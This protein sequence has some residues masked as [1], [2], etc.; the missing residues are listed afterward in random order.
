MI[1]EWTIKKERGNWRPLLE[2]KMKKEAWEKALRVA[3]VETRTPFPNSYNETETNRNYTDLAPKTWRKGK[4][5]F[6]KIVTPSPNS[7]ELTQK[8]TLP[9]RL[10][11]KYPDVKILILTLRRKYEKALKEAYD[12]APFEIS[13]SLD[14]S[15]EC[16][17]HV[18]PGIVKDRILKAVG[19]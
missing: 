16:K 18:A 11:N 3:S 17:K 5:N 6:K 9:Q 1:I 13:D 19:S 15:D 14:M 8:R 10:R 12:S 7:D 2:I 4:S